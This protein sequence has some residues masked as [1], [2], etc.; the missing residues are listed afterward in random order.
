MKIHVGDVLGS[1]ELPT[2]QTGSV[3]MPDPAGITR[4]Q[5]RRYAG[6]PSTTCTGGHFGLPADFLFATDERVI[7]ARCG[8][9]A[10]DHRTV[11]DL[12]EMVRGSA[13]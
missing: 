11:D 6:C 2:V 12:L 8:A 3:R 1:R 13:R 4:V 5:F 10:N 7:A 9:D